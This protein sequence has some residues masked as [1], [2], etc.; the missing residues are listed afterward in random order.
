ML[1]IFEDHAITPIGHPATARSALWTAIVHISLLLFLLSLGLSPVMD[2]LPDHLNLTMITAPIPPPP[3]PP[4]ITRAAN[5]PVRTP[6]RT[7]NARLVAPVA[8]PQEVAIVNTMDEAP[9]DLGVA[10]WV[11]G[12]IPGGIVRGAVGSLAAVVQPPPPPPPAAKIVQAAPPPPPPPPARIQVSAEVQE[13]KLLQMV[14]PVYPQAAK[15]ARITGTVHLHAIIDRQ[16][17]ISELET[18]EGHPL[19]AAAA[20]NAVEKWHYQPTILNG[21]AVEVATDIIV[22]FRFL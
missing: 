19:L 22:N 9:P 8:I 10:G 14:K 17:N 5:V 3:P 7:F 12:G 15:M 6:R 21:Q 2:V 4:P 20:R 11:P 18:V 16:G 13:G 1:Q